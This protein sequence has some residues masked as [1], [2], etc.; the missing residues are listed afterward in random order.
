MLDANNVGIYYTK[1][2][3]YPSK[4]GKLWFLPNQKYPEIDLHEATGNNHLYGEVRNLLH[5][6]QMDD[7]HYGTTEWNP[8]GEIIKS[9]DNV[10]LKPNLV[11]DHNKN[12]AGGTDCLYTQAAVVLPI[13]DYV[14][15][16]LEG[17]GGII[18]GDAP[19]QDCN[20]EKL[21][22]ES[23]YEDIVRY[24]QEKGVSIS[25]VDF[26]GLATTK[27]AGGLV[28]HQTIK[29]DA[30]GTIIDLKESSKFAGLDKDK[31]DNLRI[32]NYAPERLQQHHCAGKHEYYISDDVLSADVIINLPKPKTHRK[33]G[34][35]AAMKNIVGIN[36]RKEYLPHHTNG[37]VIEGGDEYRRKSWLRR[38]DDKLLDRKNTYEGQEK[39]FRASVMLLFAGGIKV[40]CDRIYKNEAEGNWY[41]NHTISKTIA[42]LNKILLY[43]DKN[44]QIQ[45]QPQRKILSIGDMIICGEK[46]GPVMPSPRKLGTLVIGCCHY[47]FDEAV[48]TMMGADISRI[49]Q[50]KEADK[51]QPESGTVII[52]NNDRLNHKLLSEVACE[53]KWNL[54]PSSG[55][56]EVFHK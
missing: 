33:A 51:L 36:V 7:V 46:E 39:Y 1:T 30:K 54:V 11:M 35:T 37:S 13:I 42:D 53:D 25:L 28:R 40:L 20:F 22:A 47:R 52:S 5:L 18:I 27:G 15:K 2:M 38:V 16:A 49:P 55:W 29:P 24:Y 8:F 9:G 44:G 32:T 3:E 43:A 12:N 17:T 23:G 6:Y 48:G 26:R 19:M 50:M 45:N 14:I 10:L 21:I 4:K 34:F 41:G 31:M 56:R